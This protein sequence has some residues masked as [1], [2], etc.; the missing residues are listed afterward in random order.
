MAEPIL[1]D[2]LW[3]RIEPLI[4][5]PKRRNRHVR[6]AGRRP[7][8]ARKVMAGIIFSLKTGVPWEFLPA[9]GQ[10]PSGQAQ[11]PRIGGNWVVN[12]MC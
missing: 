3:Q 1:S 6:Y 12:I 5:K 9:T 11:T 10:W 2:D 8:D 4:P 7:V